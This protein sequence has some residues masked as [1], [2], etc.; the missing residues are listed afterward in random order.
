MAIPLKLFAQRLLE[1]GI[2]TADDILEL[3]KKYPKS[4]DPESAMAFAQW[5]I[6]FGKLTPLQADRICKGEHYSLLLGN[7]ML[8]EKIGE[9]GMGEVFKA[10]HRRMKRLV[11]VKILRPELLDSEHALRRFQREVHAAAQLIHPNI[12]TAYDADTAGELHFLVMEY[13]DGTDLGTLV[14]RQGPLTPLKAVTYILQAARGL[15]YAHRKGIIHR[16]I[17]PANLLLDSSGTIKILDMGL[18][19]FDSLDESVSDDLTQENQIIGT[20]DYMAPEQA[21]DSKAVDRRSDIYS[22]GCTFYRLLSG[23]TPYPGS[24]PLMVLMAHQKSPPPSL[25]ELLGPDARPLDAVFQKMI[26]KRPED[27]YQEMSEVIAD[28]ERFIPRESRAPEKPDADSLDRHPGTSNTVTGI[29]SDA[30]AGTNQAPTASYDDGLAHDFRLKAGLSATPATAGDRGSS[31]AL[32]TPIGIDLGTTNSL[33]AKLDERG[34]PVTIIGSE[35]D[36]LTPSVVLFDEDSV[37]VG[38]EAVRA[39]VTERDLIAESPK[40]Q[41]GARLFEKSLRGTLY[42][43]EVLQAFILRRLRQDIERQ[44]EGPRRV[45]I[46]VPAYFDEVRRRATADAGYIAGLDVLDVL[47]EPTAAALAYGVLQGIAAPEG[48]PARLMVY[49]LGGG[50]FDVTVMEI[51][52]NVYRMLSTDGDMQLG[53]RDWDQRLIDVLAEQFI[54]EHGVDPRDDTNQLGRMWRDCEEAKRTLSVRQRTFLACEYRGRTLQL[55]LTRAAFQEMTRDLL[56]RTA[57]TA[58]EALRA[59]QLNWSDIDRVLL[60]G[61]ATRMPAVVDML[62]GLTGKEPDRSIAPDEAVAHGAALYAGML[63]ARMRGEPT[64]FSIVNVNSHSLG[65][66]ANDPRTKQ[67]RNVILIRRNTPLPAVHRRVFH[68]HKDGQ[69]S[70]LL[71]IVEGESKVPEEC[72]QVG[73]CTVHDLPPNLPARTPVEVV[74]TYSES[75]RLGISVV[76]PGSDKRVEQT[77]SSENRLSKIDLQAWRKLVCGGEADGES[78]AEAMAGEPQTH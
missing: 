51:D 74:F 75:G 27:R 76:V 11:V 1:S 57:F 31:I 37:I 47:N 29:S 26:A 49:D 67:K 41:I 5:L 25:I 7:N 18:A 23:R 77:V 69:R 34:R 61:G 52:G 65:I 30:T 6:D 38:K 32:G 64:P 36:L 24:S 10:E 8:L 68:T 9:G 60:V 48:R 20:V 62:T 54:R 35:G 3:R 2:L 55:E 58:Q 14:S 43:P 70:L 16:D 50:T 33:A 66:V 13:V 4:G 22:L 44:T 56:D 15:E 17:K 28:L 40:R 59:A 46:T 45:V 39:L 63:L 21:Q 72:S 78:S 19:R 12:V 42:P 71:Q 53:G 73:R